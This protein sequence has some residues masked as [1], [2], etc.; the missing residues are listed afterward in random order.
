MEIIAEAGSNHNGD[1][2]QA[3]KLVETAKAAG[4][5]SVKFQFI[6]PDGLYVPSFSGQGGVTANLAYS[7]RAQ[8][9]LPKKDWLKVWREASIIGIPV[10]ASVFCLKGVELLA[11]LG[12]P[13]VKIAS[14][15]LTN[16][17][18][19][20]QA[21]E[22]FPQ[23]IIS[24]GMASIPEIDISVQFLRRE[25]SSLDFRLMH[26]V[27]LYPCPVEESNPKR[28][29]ALSELFGGAVGYSDHT[30]D[31]TSALL[32]LAHGA[33]FFEKHFTTSRTL[34]GFDHANALEPEELASYIDVLNSAELALSRVSSE[35][36]PLEE[37]TKV[38]ARRGIYAAADLPKGHIISDE[39]I[40]H[41]R[42]S[43]G[44][45]LVPSAVVGRQLLED[46]RRFDSLQ[47][48]DGFAKSVEISNAAKRHWESEMVAKGM[49]ADPA[50]P[51]RP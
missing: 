9:Q 30:R 13:Y 44:S 28:V 34:S 42:P 1:V 14:T 12:A 31:T 41:V 35:N 4:A 33:T 24:T 26:C 17:D 39:D 10:S 38:R 20:R 27:S 6:F 2:E 22:I 7:Q 16:L 36:S 5:S 29:R 51:K 37:E 8:E 49:M 43:N 19:I 18:L 50:R 15:D 25:F 47:V 11:D 21:A 48:F 45:N 40:L 23:V 46:V 32:A 3:L